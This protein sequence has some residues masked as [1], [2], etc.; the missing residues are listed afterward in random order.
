MSSSTYASFAHAADV[1]ADV[2]GDVVAGQLDEL[3]DPQPGLDDDDEHG[4]V[5][6]ACPC[7]A[8]GCGEEGVE[9]LATEVRRSNASYVW[10]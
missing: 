7:A 5:A 2:E 9:A 3:G 6:P 8:V 1:G 4:V 10:V